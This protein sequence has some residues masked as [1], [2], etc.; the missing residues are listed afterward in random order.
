MVLCMDYYTSGSLTN[1]KRLLEHIHFWIKR[2]SVDPDQLEDHPEHHDCSDRMLVHA[3][4]IFTFS[5]SLNHLHD[6]TLSFF[7]QERHLA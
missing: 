4:I 1:S 5:D 6:I 7:A 3:E 2:A